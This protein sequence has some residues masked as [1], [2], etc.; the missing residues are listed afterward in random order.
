MNF[1]TYVLNIQRKDFSTS[2]MF[3]EKLSSA[4]KSK[5]PSS[6]PRASEA[7]HSASP[8]AQ[9][10][11]SS[12]CKNDD[13]LLSL[14]PLTG[15]LHLSEREVESRSLRNLEGLLPYMLKPAKFPASD[16]GITL[17]EKELMHNNLVT[18]KVKIRTCPLFI[19]GSTGP[20]HESRV[21]AH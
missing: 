8:I 15:T 11:A 7:M 9:I 2:V 21:L 18:L 1:R 13:I 5:P 16:S 17:V 19:P 14:S 3:W 12:K 20:S 4:S 6:L 10:V